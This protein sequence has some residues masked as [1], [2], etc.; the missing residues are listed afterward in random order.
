MT[1][2]PEYSLSYCFLFTSFIFSFKGPA[3]SP[4]LFSLWALLNAVPISCCFWRRASRWPQIVAC[5]DKMHCLPLR[6][7]SLTPRVVSRSQRWTATVCFLYLFF[8]FI[9]A[10]VPTFHN[11]GMPTGTPEH[12]NGAWKLRVSEMRALLTRRSRYAREPTLN[13]ST[14]EGRAN[15]TALLEMRNFVSAVKMETA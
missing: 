4:F 14:L 12:V 3:A 1:R 13:L 2:K 6:A 8:F 9:R 7:A 15:Y 11:L 5:A 10:C